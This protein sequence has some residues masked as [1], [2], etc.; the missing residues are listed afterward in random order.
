MAKQSPVTVAVR[1]ALERLKRATW[2]AIH[3]A[4]TATGVQTTA[5]A[6]RIALENLSRRGGA[7]C[8]GTQRV[9]GSRRP[10]RLYGPPR[11]PADTVPLGQIMN[12]WGAP[13]GTV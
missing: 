4:L 13:A 6:V 12:L 10:M 11:P 7:D 8:Y 1:E 5:R 3:A 2:R 9:P